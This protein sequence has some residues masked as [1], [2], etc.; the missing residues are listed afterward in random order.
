M[1][2]GITAITIVKKRTD[3][4]TTTALFFNLFAMALIKI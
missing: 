2:D 1:G 4:N 3:T